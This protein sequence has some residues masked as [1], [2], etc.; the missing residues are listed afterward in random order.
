MRPSKHGWR[1]S[2]L[3]KHEPAGQAVHR[4]AHRTM[5]RT[6][7]RRAETLRQARPRRATPTLNPQEPE[8]SDAGL[9][10]FEV[11]ARHTTSHPRPRHAYLPVRPHSDARRPLP[12]ATQPMRSPRHRPSRPEQPPRAVRQLLGSSRRKPLARYQH[13]GDRD[14]AS[15]TA[16]GPDEGHGAVAAAFAAWARSSLCILPMSAT[17]FPTK[18]TI[19][20]R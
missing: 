5:H 2:G 3:K 17:R 14:R 20:N 7:P 18:M 4:D 11:A 1:R 13:Q 12:S 8:A 9:P 10:I 15:L 19:S 16:A 6:N